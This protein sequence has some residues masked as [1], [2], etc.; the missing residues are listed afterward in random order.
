VKEKE[1][2]PLY[3]Y[4]QQPF[5]GWIGRGRS[6]AGSGRLYLVSEEQKKD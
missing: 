1:S 4:Q 2:L 6:F 5:H 3:E